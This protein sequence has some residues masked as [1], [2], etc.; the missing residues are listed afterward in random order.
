M[1]VD[2]ALK[3]SPHEFLIWTDTNNDKDDY[4]DHWT[5]RLVKNGDQ[6][7]IETFTVALDT[8]QIHIFGHDKS[9]ATMTYHIIE[10]DPNRKSSHLNIHET[11]RSQK[12][13]NDTKKN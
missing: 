8:T 3:F 9:T 13:V 11:I 12:K 5:K 6:M 2:V 1:H 7:R 4:N 10:V